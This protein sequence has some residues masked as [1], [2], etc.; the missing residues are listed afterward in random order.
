MIRVQP[1]AKSVNYPRTHP[2]TPHAIAA[3]IAYM[4]PMRRATMG[5]TTSMKNVPFT[6]VSDGLSM[7]DC[8]TDRAVACLSSWPID[9]QQN[10]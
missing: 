3:R 10:E 1:R 5:T 9:G 4:R 6:G 7:P 8:T 2:I